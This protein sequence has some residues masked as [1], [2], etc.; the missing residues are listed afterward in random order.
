M[1]GLLIRD[2]LNLE[3]FCGAPFVLSSC[4]HCYKEGEHPNIYLSDYKTTYIHIY[5][6]INT[7]I[8]I[9]IY[10]LLY[11]GKWIHQLLY[12]H[13]CVLFFPPCSKAKKDDANPIVCRPWGISSAA[14]WNPWRLWSGEP[15]RG[16]HGHPNFGGVW[17]GFHHE[18]MG[19]SP[20]ITDIQVLY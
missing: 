11:I 15:S 2:K 19:Q 9:Y 5:I 3:H 14:S 8:Y 4:G 10:L 16:A 7:Y 6:Y 17:R 13:L 12:V 18:L 1:L 20:H